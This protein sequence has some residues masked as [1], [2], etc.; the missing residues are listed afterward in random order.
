MSKTVTMMP[1]A[2][3]RAYFCQKTVPLARGLLG[4]IL[5][6]RLPDGRRMAG[7]IVETEAY[8]AT[9]AASHSFRGQTTRNAAMFLDGGHAYVYFI[10]GLHYCVNVVSE[11]ASNGA[12]VLIRA[13][14]PLEGLDLMRANRGAVA[15]YQLCR[16]P[17]NV[18]KAL[19]I[20]GAL[21]G[22]DLL[23]PKGAL[24]LE[25]GAPVAAGVVGRSPRIGIGGDVATRSRQWRFFERG[26]PCVSG[27][28]AI[29]RAAPRPTPE[30][31]RAARTS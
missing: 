9:D 10:Y 30:R 2:W 26:N 4:A 20:D 3:S 15:S 12:A 5:V 25:P 7:R 22:C 29:N 6:R 8:R 21:N 18:C 17:A 14:E 16:G 19:G 23:D 24:Q 13:I 27:S 31:A 1:L 11:P 28:S